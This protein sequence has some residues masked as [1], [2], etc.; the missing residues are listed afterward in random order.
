M[1]VAWTWVIAGTVDFKLGGILRPA[2]E[3]GEVLGPTGLMVLVGL[4]AFGIGKAGLMPFHRWL[5]NA[6][7][8]PTPVSALL[9]AV[10]VVKAGVFSVLKVVVY[11]LGT[12]LLTEVGASTWLMYVAGFTI[13]AASF[14][15]LTKD[16][17]K[18][19]LA[20][21]TI[22]QLAYIVLGAAM[23]NEAGI[24]GGGMHIATHAVGKI[25]LFFCAGAIYVATNKKNISDMRGLGRAMPWTFAAFGVD[26][27]SVIGLPPCGG[28][29][30]KWY[31]AVGAFDTGQWALVA[32]LMV[33]SLL[34][35]AY[36]M[37]VVAAG[38]F[39]DPPEGQNEGVREPVLCVAPL[40]F[41]AAGCV[42]L[43]L[44]SG[45]L[46]ELLLPIAGGA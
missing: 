19:R 16:N 9:H 6:M 21:S 15:A 33:S 2:F 35:I 13:I 22:S 46:Y 8:A 43:F 11:I 41:T 3:S 39:L 24:L 36:L 31:L 45:P 7:V 38:F 4:F 12:D 18:E 30:S 23:A 28:A 34:N 26:A 1:A 17:L 37:P 42:G 20:Y 27:V 32:V 14:I 10:A 29:W 5:P 40:C 25:T 44:F